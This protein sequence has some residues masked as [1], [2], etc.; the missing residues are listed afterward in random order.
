MIL[1]HEEVM[2]NTPANALVL[3]AERGGEFLGVVREWIKC[4]ARN[5]ETVEWGSGDILQLG[6]LSVLELEALAARIAASAANETRDN[7]ASAL[8]LKF[9]GGGLTGMDAKKTFKDNPV[10]IAPVVTDRNGELDHKHCIG[11][12]SWQTGGL[13]FGQGK[14]NAWGSWEHGCIKCNHKHAVENDA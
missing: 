6:G 3:H 12:H 10:I 9:D 14:F 13:V 7:I 5:G 2:M 1:S 11:A 8:A 4:K